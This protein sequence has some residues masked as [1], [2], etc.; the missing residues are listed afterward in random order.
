MPNPGEIWRIRQDITDLVPCSAI[1]DHHPFSQPARHFLEGD[2]SSRYVMIVGDVYLLSDYSKVLALDPSMVNTALA[3]PKPDDLA[4]DRMAQPWVTV[5]VLG[6]DQYWQ[7][8]RA[9]PL[10]TP[11]LST[12]QPDILSHA[13]VLLPAHLSGLDHDVIAETWHIVPM[14]VTQLWHPAGHRLSSILYNYLMDI[15]DVVFNKTHPPVSSKNPPTPARP[16][17]VIPG[18]HPRSHPLVQA[19]HQFEQQWSEVLRL[20]ITACYMQFERLAKTA[21]IMDKAI[22]LERFPFS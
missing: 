14:L 1:L 4:F 13:D 6:N 7:E 9:R 19:F 20:P 16:L 10:R 11:Q 8:S 18:I 21:S 3:H 17:A 22:Q 12:P 15:G 5:M 2:G